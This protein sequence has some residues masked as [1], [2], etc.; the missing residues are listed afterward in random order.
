MLITA[1]VTL[2]FLSSISVY[3]F[4]LKFCKINVKVAVTATWANLPVWLQCFS[5]CVEYQL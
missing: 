2:L 5:K 4:M 1:I 3:V